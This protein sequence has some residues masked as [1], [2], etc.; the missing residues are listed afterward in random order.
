MIPVVLAPEPPGFDA[1]VRAKGSAWLTRRGHP[2][3][4]PKPAGLK[5][6]DY[7]RACLPDLRR[8]YAEICCYV[9][10]WVPPLVGF[11]TVEHMVAKSNA[12]ELAYEWSN[13]RFACGAMN[14][15]HSDFTDVLDPMDLTLSPYALEFAGME[16]HVRSD[17]GEELHQMAQRTLSRLQLNDEEC[18]QLRA[19]YWDEYIAGHISADYLRRKSPFVHAEAA[20]QALLA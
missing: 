3:K 17:I 19:A 16:L 15:R 12:L 5:L 8:A 6:A 11:A 1:T 10:V 2:T 4:G 13:Y 9:A 14:G 7:W 18:R 20:R